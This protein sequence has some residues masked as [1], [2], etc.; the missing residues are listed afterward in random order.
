MKSRLGL[1]KA[2]V[3]LCLYA[4]SAASFAALPSFARVVSG[5]AN[6]SLGADSLTVQ[7][8]GDTTIEWESFNVGVNESVFF[9]Q[10]QTGSFW[11]RNIVLDTAPTR[12]EGSVVSNG[13]LLIQADQFWLE[14]G[15]SI[16]VSSGGSFAL[17]S[18]SSAHLL[19]TI[20]VAGTDHSLGLTGPI[21]SGTT[22]SVAGY[23]NPRVPHA[24]LV[25]GLNV[26]IVPN[27]SPLLPVPEPET[28]M[29]VLAGLGLLSLTQRR[30]NKRFA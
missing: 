27:F 21:Y 15:A 22:I 2:G 25:V 30:R 24:E 19:G 13:N 29:L 18:N 26:N 7:S 9:D 16:S 20:S 14:A 4:L 6:F 5:S 8:M 12:I 3:A 17:I 10:L 1:A 11:V 28:Y 23:E